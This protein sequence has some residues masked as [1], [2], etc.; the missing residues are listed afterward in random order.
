VPSCPAHRAHVA[1][2]AAAARGGSQWLR[3][4]VRGGLNADHH[5][6]LQL[7]RGSAV[8]QRPTARLYVLVSLYTSIDGQ[9]ITIEPVPA[10]DFVQFVMEKGL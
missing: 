9:P 1:S 8:A 10:H 3:S 4:E 5:G 7:P 2:T 6:G